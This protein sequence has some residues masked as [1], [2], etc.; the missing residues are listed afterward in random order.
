MTGTRK[1]RTSAVPVASAHDPQQ[2]RTV[3]PAAEPLVDGD[4]G[5]L[6]ARLARFLE[7]PLDRATSLLQD[8]SAFAALARAQVAELRAQYGLTADQAIRLKDALYL[9]QRLLNEPREDRPH[10]RSHHDVGRLMRPRIGGLDHEEMW[11]VLLDAKNRV[12]AQVQ[13]YVGTV[14]TCCVR[15]AEIFRE[16]IRRNAPQLIL[17]HN[18]PS[19]DPTP[20]PED[21]AH[22]RAVVRA[23]ALLDIAVLDHVILG[24]AAHVSLREHYGQVWEG[25]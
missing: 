6:D 16:P 3:T 14:D 25:S 23:G 24:R 9:G 5:A 21:I 11:V 4:C 18:H 20:S 15:T 10:I 22:T 2:D 13:L 7:I 17:T 12:V 1:A 19:A 8:Y